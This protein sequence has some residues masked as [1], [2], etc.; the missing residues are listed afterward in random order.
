[1]LKIQWDANKCRHAGICVNSLPE[2]FRIEDGQFK[3]D[4]NGAEAERIRE[5]VAQCPSGALAIEEIEEKRGI[6]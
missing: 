5:V 6:S 1:M 2:V 3:I 4:P